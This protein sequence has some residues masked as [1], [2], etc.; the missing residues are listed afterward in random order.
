MDEFHLPDKSNIRYD[1]AMLPRF[2]DIE[3]DI[4]HNY[5][6]CGLYPLYEKGYMQKNVG[7]ILNVCESKSQ[8]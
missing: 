5:F 4:L 8:Y 2:L 7:L 6:H 1:Y 3:F